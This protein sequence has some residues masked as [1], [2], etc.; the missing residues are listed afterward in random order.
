M[1]H[2]YRRQPVAPSPAKPLPA[3]AP[4][5]AAAAP[6]PAVTSSG[7]TWMYSERT[8]MKEELYPESKRS[9]A[10]H[11]TK[12][13]ETTAQKSEPVSYYLRAYTVQVK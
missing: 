13:I 11:G 3:P 5:P 4:A 9:G 12:H 10:K 1:K 6:A 8:E 2:S 7:K